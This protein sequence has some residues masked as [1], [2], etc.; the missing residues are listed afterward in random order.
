MRHAQHFQKITQLYLSSVDRLDLT[1]R[2][3]ILQVS[4][5][6]FIANQVADD[7]CMLCCQD[8][9][10]D[11]EPGCCRDSSAS[12]HVHL[13]QRNSPA[14]PADSAFLLAPIMALAASGI[15]RS[16]A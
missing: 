10:I 13:C 9:K 15:M 8:K 4:S 11:S 2:K 14:H 7:Q 5:L 1:G 12:A 3:T 6:Q 16:T